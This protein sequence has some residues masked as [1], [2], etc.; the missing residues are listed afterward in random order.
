MHPKPGR[1]TAFTMYFIS[2]KHLVSYKAKKG[3]T[4]FTNEAT[5]ITAKVTQLL[6]GRAYIQCKQFDYCRLIALNDLNC[7]HVCVS[8]SF[9]T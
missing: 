2:F 1:E 5:E 6:G 4:H 8:T 9:A 3:H 7:S